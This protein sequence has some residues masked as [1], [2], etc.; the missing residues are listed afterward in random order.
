V[1]AVRAAVAVAFAAGL[2][3]GVK[4]YRATWN[5]LSG[6]RAQFVHFSAAER[7]QEP[8]VAQLL[9]VDAFEF[10]R[11]HLRKGDR[12]VVVAEPKNFQTGVDAAQ[13]TRVFSRYFLLPAIQVADPADADFVISV[14]LDPHSAGVPLARVWK[15]GGGQYFVGAVRR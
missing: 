6:Q 3:S 2:V 13:A 11:S 1:T 7:R 14:G 5:W 10:F 4:D 15:F 8:G 12:Y 9:P